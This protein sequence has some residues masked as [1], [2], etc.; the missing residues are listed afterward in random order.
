MHKL[1]KSLLEK[2]LCRNS[3]CISGRFLWHPRLR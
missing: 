2:R 1:R 3:K